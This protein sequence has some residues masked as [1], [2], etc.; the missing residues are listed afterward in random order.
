VQ[1]SR[2]VSHW[3]RLTHRHCRQLWSLEGAVSAS[4]ASFD[5]LLGAMGDDVS[6]H[7]PV[8][9]W[10]HLPTSLGRVKHDRLIAGGAQGGDAV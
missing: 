5:A 3:N 10:D 2:C 4:S 8:A 6:E 9:A 7:L 1:W